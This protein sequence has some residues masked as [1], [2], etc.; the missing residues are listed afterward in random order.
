MTRRPDSIEPL[1]AW[2]DAP[3]RIA[4]AK[5]LVG[6]GTL[7][8]VVFAG[9]DYITSV[10]QTRFSVHFEFESKLPFVPE[11]S[12]IYSSVYLMFA[13]IALTLRTTSELR[14]FV[15]AMAVMTVVAGVCF[16]IYPAQL[17]F[18]SVT[19]SGWAA[20]PL[21]W[22]DR[23]NLTYN[24]APSLHVAYAVLCSEA[25][26]RNRGIAGAVFHLWALAIAVSAWLTFQHHLVDLL[27]GYALGLVFGSSRVQAILSRAS[28]R[29]LGEDLVDDVTVNVG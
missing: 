3:Q 24:C 27:T 20:I 5:A 16:L 13:F 9:T 14:R 18:R 10:R 28:E 6:L 17:E 2:P 19:V 15:V 26:R 23:I 11:L 4:L 22:A 12:V 8:W 7:F 29:F 1:L 25:M 21:E